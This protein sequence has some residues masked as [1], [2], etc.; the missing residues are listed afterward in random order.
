MKRITTR[1][2]PYA[3]DVLL[4]DQE[5]MSSYRKAFYD[6]LAV[7]AQGDLKNLVDMCRPALS[8]TRQ[9]MLLRGSDLPLPLP[10]SVCGLGLDG[11]GVQHDRLPE[12]SE[13]MDG[14]KRQRTARRPL[15]GSRANCEPGSAS[16]L[17]FRRQSALSGGQ[18]LLVHDRPRSQAHHVPD[19]ASRSAT[20]W[21]SPGLSRGGNQ[22]NDVSV[23][24][25]WDDFLSRRG[26]SRHPA[27]GNR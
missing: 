13:S 17:R 8:R 5:A 6:A 3:G 23:N 12:L 19:R 2:F 25:A 15:A 26:R 16:T 1:P 10:P 24:S 22:W 4:S 7:E 27:A 21:I 14:L 11:E 20:R 18:L 9:G